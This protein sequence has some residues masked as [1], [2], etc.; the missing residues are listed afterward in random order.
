MQDVFTTYIYCRSSNFVFGYYSPSYFDGQIPLGRISTI[1]WPIIPR[2]PRSYWG[3]WSHFLCVHV[4]P[5]ISRSTLATEKFLH[6]RFRPTYFKHTKNW[7]LYKLDSGFLAMFK[8]RRGAGSRYRATYLN[9]LYEC[10]LSFNHDKF[11]PVDVHHRDLGISIVSGWNTPPS[12]ENITPIPTMQSSFMSLPITLRQTVGSVYFPP[13]NG[14][15][16][17][18]KIKN[19]SVGI[20]G[21]S[22][23]SLKMI[24]RLMLGFFCLVI[25]MTLGSDASYCGLWPS[26]WILPL[27][28]IFQGGIAGYHCISH[29][30]QAFPLLPFLQCSCVCYM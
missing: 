5:L 6:S 27:S 16:L 30:N 20:F 3:L 15:A 7:H 4:L 25:S 22:G 14:V 29:H 18:S 8:L 28:I 10:D 9:N 2:P 1:T 11:Y 26:S 19:K 12:V 21:A 23:A 13:D 24:G 17:L